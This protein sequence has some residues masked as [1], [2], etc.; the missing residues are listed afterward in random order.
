MREDRA[1]TPWRPNRVLRKNKSTKPVVT[2]S[3]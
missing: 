2:D 1:F 3:V